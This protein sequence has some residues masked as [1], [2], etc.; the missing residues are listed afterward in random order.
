MQRVDEK[1]RVK[2]TAP[3][4]STAGLAQHHAYHQP[5]P[6][7]L[8]DQW[9]TE[10]ADAVHEDVT[11][12]SGTSDQ[13]LPVNRFEHSQPGGTRHHVAAEG[14]AVITGPEQLRRRTEGHAGAERQ[15]PWRVTS[16]CSM[17]GINLDIDV[18][19]RELDLVARPSR[20]TAR[21]MVS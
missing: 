1:P 16:P 9:V 2:Q 10:V 8:G 15:S 19:R 21:V 5:A 17:L 20:G 14:R 7:D 6:A 12:A 18:A 11:H 4:S 13:T 3:N